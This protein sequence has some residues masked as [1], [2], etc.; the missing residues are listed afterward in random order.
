MAE[1]TKPLP[2][3]ET[4]NAPY[5]RAA[6]RHEFVAQQCRACGYIHLPPGPVCTNCLSADQGWA[7]LSGKGTIYSYGIYYQL[8]HP[9]FKEDIPYNVALIQ[10][11]EGPQIISQ[12]V[13]C[14][15]E[16]LG[17]GLEVEVVFD[18]ITTEITLPKFRLVSTNT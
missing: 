12:V 1:Y 8:W 15:N 13:G 18:D 16:E 5:W 11:A 3:I 14:K 9:G 2:V 17:C 10:L 4:W 7:R 6:K